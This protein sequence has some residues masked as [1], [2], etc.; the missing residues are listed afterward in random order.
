MQDRFTRRSFILTGTAVLVSGCD[1]IVDLGDGGW[2]LGGRAQEAPARPLSRREIESQPNA[3]LR[4]RQG[5]EIEALMTLTQGA[6]RDLHWISPRR[7][8]VATRK[9]RVVKSVGL[10]ANLRATQFLSPDPVAVGLHRADA[11]VETK[12]IVDLSG[13]QRFG[14]LII[15]RFEIV[16][17]KTISIAETSHDVLLVKERNE[18]APEGWHFENSF[19]VDRRD[20]F[21]WRSVQHI[22]PEAPPFEIDIL[23]P[24]KGGA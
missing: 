15:S 12:R 21:V 9:G 14:R 24:A 19:W 18:M 5:R 11:P 22:A 17:Q 20:G 23:K 1:K 6:G 4:L 10:Q 13:R 16:G 2:V 7:L 8:L 3:M